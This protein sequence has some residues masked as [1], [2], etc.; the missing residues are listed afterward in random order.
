MLTAYSA[1][2]L[3]Y[4]IPNFHINIVSGSKLQATT[5]YNYCLDI[6]L[7]TR[8]A[9][10]VKGE[11]TQIKTVGK[12]NSKLGILAASERQTRAPRADMLIIDE[13]CAAKQNVL[14]SVLPQ[15]ITAEK[16]K[17]VVLT[18][19][20]EM[21]HIARKWWIE[22]AKLGITRYRWDAYQ[23]EHIPNINIKR[24]RNIY[25]DAT[26]DIEVMA[27]WA[28]KSGSVFKLAQIQSSVCDLADLPPIDQIE[29][30]YL[31]IDWGDA[32]ETV[33]TI[34]GMYGDIENGTDKWFVYAVRA[35]RKVDLDVVLHGDSEDP[36]DDGI[37][38]LC[39]FYSPVIL[40]EIS[41]ISAF[42]NK[43]LQKKVADLGL[44]FH[45]V[46]FTRKKARCVANL[47]GSFNHKRIKIPKRFRRTID[48]LTNYHY[49][50]VGEEIRDEFV[51]KEDDYVDSLVWARW[52]QHPMEGEIETIG[53]V[54]LE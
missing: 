2:C 33:A 32:H 38:G 41:A 53:T 49:K 7:D 36:D 6:F 30:F 46:S 19:P 12:N 11:P 39:E 42:P 1:C 15:V 43:E 8:M 40:S 16:M 4:N 34:L 28:S 21:I 27:K 22:F 26:F 14:L 54:E 35:W 20:N 13:A 44:I 48:Q 51:K 5:C 50:M 25:D 52:G 24:L 37:I 10:W 29:H 23:C 45:E 18:T 47:R 17:I 3:L 9:G 31:G